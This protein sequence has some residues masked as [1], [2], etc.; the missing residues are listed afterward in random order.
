MNEEYEVEIKKNSELEDCPEGSHIILVFNN[1]EEYHGIFRGF[2][3]DDTIM[4]R[5]ETEKSVTIGLP[6]N[7]LKC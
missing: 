6:F 7:R 1:G 4:L 2:D 5:S 3:G